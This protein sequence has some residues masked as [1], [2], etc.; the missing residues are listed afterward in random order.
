MQFN[1]RS[2]QNALMKCLQITGS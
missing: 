1:Q 2:Y